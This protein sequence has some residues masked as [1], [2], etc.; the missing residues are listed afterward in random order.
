MVSL[1]SWKKSIAC[2]T[3]IVTYD[4]DRL[5]RLLIDGGNFSILILNVYLLYYSHENVH[6]YLMYLGKTE[7]VIHDYDDDGVIIVRDFTADINKFYYQEVCQ[8][9]NALDVF[10][11][12]HDAHTHE[13]S[14]CTYSLPDHCISSYT[15]H[16]SIIHFPV[17]DAY[18]GSNHFPP[19]TAA[20]VCHTKNTSIALQVVRIKLCTPYMKCPTER[21]A[22]WV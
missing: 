7:S 10:L 2:K 5:F 14:A 21:R 11:F 20:L 18:N 1:F 8:L 15:M 19:G 17:D 16:E 13:H 4:D 12:L 6:M 9:C 3:K 22:V